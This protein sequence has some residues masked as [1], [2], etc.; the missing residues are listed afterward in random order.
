M[1]WIQRHS[2]GESISDI[3]SRDIQDLATLEQQLLE[4]GLG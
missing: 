1:Q 3:L 4:G 2:S